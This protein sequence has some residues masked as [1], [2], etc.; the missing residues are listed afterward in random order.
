MTGSAPRGTSSWSPGC[1][2]HPAPEGSK[3]PTHRR[4]CGPLLDRGSRQEAKGAA[5]ERGQR[6]V[7]LGPT[8]AHRGRTTPRLAGAHTSSPGLE[9]RI[10]RLSRPQPL[11][12]RGRRPGEQGTYCDGSSSASSWSAG[13][14]RKLCPRHLRCSPRPAPCGPRN[15][16]S[17]PAGMGMVLGATRGTER[18]GS[19]KHPAAPR[20]DSRGRERDGQGR[21]EGRSLSPPRPSV[22]RAPEVD[23]P[24]PLAVSP[25]L[26]GAI[27]RPATLKA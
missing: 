5:P 16:A 22:R 1:T 26:E 11:G 13:P 15:S 24:L 23:K 25:S 17:E 27:G 3:D 19:W 20:R 10:L 21:A 6:P 12:L 9:R 18:D 14:Q 7:P 8:A 4:M 2:R